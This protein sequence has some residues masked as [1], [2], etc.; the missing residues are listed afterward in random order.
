MPT[1]QLILSQLVLQ[2]AVTS[3]KNRFHNIDRR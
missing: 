1:L 2:T 3:Y